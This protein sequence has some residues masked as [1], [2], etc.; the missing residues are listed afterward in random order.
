[1]AFGAVDELGNR[2]DATFAP[3]QQAVLAP[4][5]PGGKL[6]AFK[7]T[8]SAVDFDCLNKGFLPQAIVPSIKLMDCKFSK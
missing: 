4:K 8:T 2:F 7:P 6:Q 1:V 3:G 5:L